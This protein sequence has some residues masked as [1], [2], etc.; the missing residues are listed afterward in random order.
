MEA[1]KIVLE[2]GLIPSVKWLY[3]L[4]TQAPLSLETGSL[5]MHRMR[6]LAGP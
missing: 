6:E 4:K 3:S 2:Y 1:V 5:A